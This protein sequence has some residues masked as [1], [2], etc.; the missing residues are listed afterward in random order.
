MTRPPLHE[1]PAGEPG[2]PTPARVPALEAVYREH[3]AFVWR[4][5]RHLGVT[6]HA[7]DDALQDVFLV[8]HRRLPDFDPSRSLRA[9]LYG[10]ARR[11]ASEYRRGRARGTRRLV[12]VHDTSHHRDQQPGPSERVAAAHM[13]DEFLRVLDDDKRRAFVL[14]E[15]EGMTAPEIAEAE[16]ANVNTIYARLRAARLRF[17]KAVKRQRLRRQREE[18]EG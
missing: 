3:Q 5:L 7:V 14:A 9:W 13:V 6:P 1:V 18:G 15:V 12:L 16:G 4:A 17:A 8:V 11:V 2:P 10:I